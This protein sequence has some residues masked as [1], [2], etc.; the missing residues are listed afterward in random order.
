MYISISILRV[1]PAWL[2]LTML[3]PDI[4]NTRTPEKVA[5]T[6]SLSLHGQGS[7]SLLGLGNHV[8]QMKA[9]CQVYR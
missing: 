8:V 5:E 1:R 6:I 7:L 4:K 2:W 9:P 3:R